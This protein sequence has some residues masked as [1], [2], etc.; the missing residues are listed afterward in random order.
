MK[1]IIFLF[2]LMF[3]AKFIQAQDD[4]AT[5]HAE[6]KYEGKS[7]TANYDDA[8]HL[9]TLNVSVSVEIYD[10][11]GSCIKRAEGTKIDFKPLL[12]AGE[13]KTF[14]VKFYKN[15]KKKKSSAKKNASIKEKGEIGTMV[16][17][18]QK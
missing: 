13:K 8:K 6:F 9:L 14:T 10:E 3:A 2:V 18:D 12:K 4:A 17:E 7:Y 5:T 11:T 15:S 1:K 16:I